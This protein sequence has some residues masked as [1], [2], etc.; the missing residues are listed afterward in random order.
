MIIFIIV[1]IV[2]V[3]SLMP[4]KKEEE[5]IEETIAQMPRLYLK[6]KRV[7]GVK[8]VLDLATDAETIDTF[9]YENGV[10]TITM[11]N[12]KRYSS[13][14]KD[15]AFSIWK[16]KGVVFYECAFGNEKLSSHQMIFVFSDDEW[17][18]IFNVLSKSKTTYGC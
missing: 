2:I 4:K 1:F 12:G 11:R 17:K 5:K 16:Q 7:S 18:Q 14:L 6:G 13:H 10:V 8:A 15:M 3:F 9:L